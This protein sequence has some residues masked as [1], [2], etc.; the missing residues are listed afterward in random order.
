[1]VWLTEVG[2]GIT[3]GG[4]RHVSPFPLWPPFALVPPHSLTCA[5]ESVTDLW[6][7]LCVYRDPDLT[8]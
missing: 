7:L 4:Q 5:F 8:P 2:K 3:I 1:M 6:S